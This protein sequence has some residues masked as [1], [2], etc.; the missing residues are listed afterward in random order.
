MVS[1]IY[2]N[3]IGISLIF[4]G[5]FFY[6]KDNGQ[7]TT[8]YPYGYIPDVETRRGA[9]LPRDEFHAA[10]FI[11]YIFIMW[12]YRDNPTYPIPPWW[13]IYNMYY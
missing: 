7:Q 10:D 6:G 13:Y 4:K 2:W 9:S 12:Q 5:Y 8:I 3:A 11:H 1:N